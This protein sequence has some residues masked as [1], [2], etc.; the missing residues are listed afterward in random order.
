[1]SLSS[2]FDGRIG[3]F[4]AIFIAICVVGLVVAW[5]LRVWGRGIKPSA[6]RRLGIVDAYDLDR[7]RQLV[8]IRRDNV[9]HLIMIGGPN[10]L[11]I[12]SDIVRSQ[13]MVGE[14]RRDPVVAP[15]PT[16]APP[17]AAVA[18]APVLPPATASVAPPVDFRPTPPMPRA[19]P[20]AP[21]ARAPEV[22]APVAPPPP[23]PAKADPPRLSMNINSLEEE[24][25]RLLGHPPEKKD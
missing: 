13:P 11:V 10:D 4:L 1:M 14:G 15:S 7:H 20:L 22:K 24:M 18:P 8:I 9:E 17:P 12:E 6:G 2:L 21:P 16:M 25:T 5:A 19:N 23:E 3:S